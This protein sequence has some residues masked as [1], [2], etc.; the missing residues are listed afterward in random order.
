MNF[1]KKII[2][3]VCFGGMLLAVCADDSVP[4]PIQPQGDSEAVE[5]MKVV[6]VDEASEEKEVAEVVDKEQKEAVPKIFAKKLPKKDPW[7]AFEPPI[8]TEY[9]WI[10]LNSGEWLKGDFKGLYDYTVEFDS[11]ELNLQDFDFDD[12]KRLRTRGM[13]TLFMEGEGGHRDTSTFRGMLEIDGD[14]VMLKRSEHQVV[15]ARDQVISITSGKKQESDFWSGSISLGGN[16]RGGNARTIDFNVSAKVKRRTAESLLN[17]DYLSNYSHAN[18]AETANNQR[19]NIYY[20]RFFTTRFYWRTASGEYYRDP[21]SNIKNQYSLDS[22]VGL[23]LF[24]SSKIDWL[25]TVGMGY[26]N[27]EF[28]SVETQESSFSSSPFLSFG[29]Q[30]DQ[31]IT[32]SVEYSLEYDLRWLNQDNGQYTH[33]CITTLSIDIVQ[34]LDLD[35]SVV[36]DHIQKPKKIVDGSMPHKDDYQFIVS[37]GYDF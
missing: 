22:G 20:D 18:K 33:H 32:G 17:L 6:D 27:K 8:D 37:L 35:L 21:F 7:D 2:G 29:T 24:H 25:L 1:M 36:W 16:V 28:V 34:N 13:K 5:A 4:P 26:Q 10:Q 23:N 14:T 9:D 30:Y 31:E 11:K 3:M 15:V 12:V 19:L